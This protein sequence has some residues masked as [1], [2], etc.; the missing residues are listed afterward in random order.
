MINHPFKETPDEA[1]PGLFRWASRGVLRLGLWRST[2]LLTLGVW[3]VAVVLAQAII[4]LLGEGNR[5]VAVVSASTLALA[6]TCC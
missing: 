2:G 6:T 4:S 1:A 5:Y 3:I